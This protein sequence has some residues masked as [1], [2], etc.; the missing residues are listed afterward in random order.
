MKE[1]DC[2]ACASLLSGSRLTKHKNKI[3][4]TSFQDS[5]SQALQNPKPHS[6]EEEFAAV[7]QSAPLVLEQASGSVSEMKICFHTSDILTLRLF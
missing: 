1:G 6:K 4:L 7:L 3:H 5:L 2:C